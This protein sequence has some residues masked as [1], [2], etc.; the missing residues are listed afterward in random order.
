M[1]PEVHVGVGVLILHNN[2]LLLGKRNSRLGNKT[3]SLPGGHLEF[4][5][6]FEECAVREVKEETGMDVVVDRLISISNTIVYGE[7]YVTVGMLGILK[8]GVPKVMEPD[9]C[10]QWQWFELDKLPT[11]LFTPTDEAIKHYLS[12]QIY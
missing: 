9:K 8:K 2:K 7:H 4:N 12:K 5:E 3:W 6:S 10:E 1:D 11:P